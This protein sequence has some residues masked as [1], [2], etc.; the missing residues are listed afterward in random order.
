MARRR[1]SRKKTTRRRK[2]TGIN[3]VNTAELY[4]QTAVLTNG[5]MGTNPLTALTGL[6]YGTNVYGSGRS[7][8]YGTNQLG[9]FPSSATVTL[10][11]LL[12]LD[13][14]S[15]TYKSTSLSGFTSAQVDVPFGQGIQI[16]KDNAR[17]NAV[18]MMVQ[19]IGVRAGFA[20][21]KRL[22]SKQRSFINNKVLKPLNMRSMVVV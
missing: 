6:E 10:P 21:G 16:I 8:V 22:F 14:A 4:M 9:Y 7:Q 11:E 5:L 2:K 15:Q 18:Q 3:L 17:A 13:K 19:S 12:G 20:I 1:N